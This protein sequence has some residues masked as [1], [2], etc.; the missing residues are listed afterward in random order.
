[1]AQWYPKI[2]VYDENG[3]HSDVFHAEGE[4]YGEFGD[5]K[6]KFDLPKAFIIASTGVVIDGDPGWND[7]EVDTVLDYDIWL[8]IHNST[9]MEMHEDERRVVTFLAENVHDFAWVASRDLLYEGGLSR[10]SKTKIHVLYDKDR[11]EDWTKVVLERSIN[12]LDWLETKFGDYPYPQITTVDRIKNGGMEYPMLVMNGRDSESLIVHEYGHVYFYG[13]IA[14]NELDEAWLDEGLTTNQTTDYMMK[15][16]GDHGFDIKLYEDYHTFPRKLYPL[17]N[18]LHADQWSVIRYLRSG[19]NENISRPS[20]LFN[21]GMSY[22]RNAYTKPSLML[23]ELKYIL[24]DSLFYSAMQHYYSKWKLK[25]V[26][27]DRFIHA[28]Q[29]HVNLDLTWF[30]EQ[31][32]HTT[33]FRLLNL[34]F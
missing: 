12:A 1:M 25:H 3:W 14:N 29:E 17:E 16:Y 13:I 15:R 11:G 22:R 21:S 4:F 31:W 20:Y 32:L 8:D 7:V 2:A 34:S 23:F 9:N 28:I 33:K 24:G 18:D 26:N 6:V 10:N 5:F 27:E 19:H 30:F